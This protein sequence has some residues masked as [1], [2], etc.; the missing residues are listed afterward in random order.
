MLVGHQAQSLLNLNDNDCESF[1]IPNAERS[2]MTQQRENT[3]GDLSLVFADE[4]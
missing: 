2:F 1:E 3:E 4:I